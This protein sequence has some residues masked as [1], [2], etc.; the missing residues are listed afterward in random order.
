MALT[1][2][3][4]YRKLLEFSCKAVAGDQFNVREMVQSKC[5]RS[6]ESFTEHMV[7]IYVYE[8]EETQNGLPYHEERKHHSSFF[9]LTAH[10]DKVK[11]C[12]LRQC[13]WART[14]AQRNIMGAWS[15]LSSTHKVLP[16]V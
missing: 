4:S 2:V 14:F 1:M 3:L 13:D 16:I 12:I 9:R 6:V 10:W 15:K 7:F 8:S 5:C 11:D